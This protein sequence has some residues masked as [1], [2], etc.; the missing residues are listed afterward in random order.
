MSTRICPRCSNEIEADSKFCRHCAFNFEVHESQAL[1]SDSAPVAES[2]PHSSSKRAGLKLGLLIV[3][4]VI[5]VA[6]VTGI[7]V[8]YQRAQSNTRV[9]NQIS[10]SSSSTTVTAAAPNT[11]ANKL[12]NANVEAAIKRLLNNLT[13][14]GSVTVQGVQEMPQ[15]NAAVA[16]LV[17]HDFKYAADQYGSPVAASQYRPKPLPKDRLPTPEELFQPKL[18]TYSGTGRALLKHYNNNQWTLK[19][20]N[21]GSMGVGWQGNVVVR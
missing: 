8:S 19:Q 20:V 9:E 16:D 13:Q 18:R 5:V 7:L 1:R 3:G 4:I 15:E 11:E 2:Q 6:V 21:W 17:F 12:T 10:T 14:G